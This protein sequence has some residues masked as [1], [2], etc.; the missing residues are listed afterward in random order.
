MTPK[1]YCAPAKKQWKGEQKVARPHDYNCLPL[2]LYPRLHRAP[3]CP[4]PRA[5]H[6]RV[7]TWKKESYN[8]ATCSPTEHRKFALSAS[9]RMNLHIGKKDRKRKKKNMYK[10]KF[11]PGRPRATMLPSD[12]PPPPPP[13]APAPP[14][15]SPS[16]RL[17]T[18]SQCMYE[19]TRPGGARHAGD[20]GEVRGA[21]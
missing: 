5:G 6:V 16:P 17:T 19:Y 14:P 9:R 15:D 12:T 13:L 11:L 10:S 4:W 21:K 2:T 1:G 3:S 18:G 20:S 8:P 7:T